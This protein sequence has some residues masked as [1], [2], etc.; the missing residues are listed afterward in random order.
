MTEQ[1]EQVASLLQGLFPLT[2]N[3]GEEAL[4]CNILSAIHRDVPWLQQ[5]P[6]HDREIV[7][8]AGGPS[9]SESYGLIQAMVSRGATIL[10]VNNTAA[11]LSERG[12]IPQYHVLLDGRESIARFIVPHPAT[13]YLLASQCAPQTF[14]AAGLRTILWHPNIEGIRDYIGDRET[15][16]IGGGTTVGLQAMSL[17]YAL[18]YRNLYLIG[19]DSSYRGTEGHAYPQAENVG[20]PVMT[21]NFAGRTFTCARWMVHQAEEFKGVLRQLVERDCTVR[22]AGDGFLQATVKEMQQTALTAVYDLA[23]SPPTYD[24]L[25]FLCAAEKARIQ[26]GH[27]FVDVVFVPGPKDGFRDDYLPPSRAEREGM[28]HRICVSACRLLPSVRNVTILKERQPI[29]G[30]IFPDGW[31]VLTPVSHYGIQW[32][33]QGLPRVLRATEGARAMPKPDGP[34]VTITIR[35]AEYWPSRNSDRE[36]WDKA[37]WKMMGLGYQVVWI[38]DTSKSLSLAAWDIDYRLAL[39]EGAVCNL[40]VS[41]GPFSLVVLSECPYL[42]FMLEG[43]DAPTCTAEFMRANGY[44]RGD[45][46]SPNGRV[47]WKHDSCDVIVSELI[48]Y[49]HL[50]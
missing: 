6:A 47:V 41:G 30:D 1:G 49:L 23:V 36:E 9:L 32:I 15:A 21:V 40:M 13:T 10:A 44:A 12:I 27:T 34:Y 11:W 17:A 8:V 38:D 26:R 18:G 5:Q 39:Y 29:S 48:N 7:L 24:F 35:D 3:V 16:L 31:T 33:V 50:Q 20:E 2:I 37:A 42:M 46:F 19:Y 22:V 28:L 14:D 45:Q 25:L 4:R 43:T